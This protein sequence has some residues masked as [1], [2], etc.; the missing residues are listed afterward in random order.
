MRIPGGARFEGY[1]SSQYGGRSEEISAQRSGKPIYTTDFTDSACGLPRRRICSRLRR[2]TSTGLLNLFAN[3]YAPKR[4][5]ASPSTM[6]A[7]AVRVGFRFARIRG[8]AG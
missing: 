6:G 7:Q 4:E 3:T 5:R 8:H 1:V 2:G